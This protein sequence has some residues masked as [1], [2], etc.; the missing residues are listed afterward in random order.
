M[1][2]RTVA[3]FL[4]GVMTLFS[5]VLLLRNSLF[6]NHGPSV[7]IG[8][9]RVWVEVAKSSQEARVGL[10]GRSSLGKDWGMLFL[11]PQEGRYPFWMNGMKF[12]LDFVFIMGEEVVDLAENIPFPK[13]GEQP[14]IV[15]A[16]KGFDRVL[17]INA[18]MIQKWKIKLGDKISP[19]EGI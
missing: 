7:L 13:E 19:S 4:F 5:V 10:S 1:N 3:I 17:E 18:G 16:Q 12:N 8:N 11:F 14:Q 6:D 15:V 9:Q 2:S